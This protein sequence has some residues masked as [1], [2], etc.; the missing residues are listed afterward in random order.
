M[1]SIVTPVAI[2]QQDGP[3]VSSPDHGQY[4]DRVQIH[5]S[6][7]TSQGK[8]FP[9]SPEGHVPQASGFGPCIRCLYLRRAFFSS[10]PKHR[11]EHWVAREDPCFEIGATSVFPSLTTAFFRL[12]VFSWLHPWRTIDFLAEFHPDLQR[13]AYKVLTK[14]CQWIATL[15]FLFFLNRPPLFFRLVVFSWL[16]HW[17]TIDFPSSCRVSL[18]FVK[19]S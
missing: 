2:A 8:Q 1:G 15:F 14:L 7:V 9:T 18:R 13:K 19:D 16:H 17:C 5:V 10:K 12:I 11:F 4:L 3:R 6:V